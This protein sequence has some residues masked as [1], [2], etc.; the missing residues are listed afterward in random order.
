MIHVSN[1]E[2]AM[3]VS[4]RRSMT[5]FMTLTTQH[6]NM[7]SMPLMF[8][9]NTG[10]FGQTHDFYPIALLL[11]AM[12]A[13]KRGSKEVLA[14]SGFLLVCVDSH[15]MLRYY[16]LAFSLSSLP[17]SIS[18][19]IFPFFPLSQLHDRSVLC[20]FSHPPLIRH[21]LSLP[22]PSSL[23]YL[24]SFTGWYSYSSQGHSDVL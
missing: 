2:T 21:I 6:M 18:F 22:L 5:G 20:L 10:D 23:P 17:F 9:H 8:L 15:E 1:D 14:L 12:S 11:L 24:F 16:F 13:I 19:P 4:M 7:T 3:L